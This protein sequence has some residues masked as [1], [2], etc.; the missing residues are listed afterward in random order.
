MLG[1]GLVLEELNLLSAELNCLFDI[2]DIPKAG[3]CKKSGGVVTPRYPLLRV[4]ASLLE[5]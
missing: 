3:S 4:L 2:T 1:G 5:G